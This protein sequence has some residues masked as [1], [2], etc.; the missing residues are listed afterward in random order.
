MKRLACLLVLA[1]CPPKGGGVAT[2]VSNGIGCPSAS[3]V[4]V[5][6]YA[7]PDE[8]GKGHTGWVLPLADKIVPSVD[9][10]A[11]YATIDAAAAQAANVPAP[12]LNLYLMAPNTRPCRPTIG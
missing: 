3:G 9:G 10:I 4:Y 11:D 2:P 1:G 6:S 8:G 5:A 7:T 12:P